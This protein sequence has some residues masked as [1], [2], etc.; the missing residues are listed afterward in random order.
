MGT[1]HITAADG[2][3]YEVEAA[4]DQAARELET[5]INTR[6]KAGD[7]QLMGAS[8]PGNTQ[9]LRPEASRKR[10]IT[11]PRN[12]IQDA[13]AKPDIKSVIMQGIT[14]GLSDEA[15]GLGGILANAI[16][17]PLSS[18]V[19]FDPSGAYRRSRDAE[20]ARIEATRKK[21][22]W[23]SFGGELGGSLLTGGGAAANTGKG[24]GALIRQGAKVGAASGALSGFGY[25]EGAENSLVGA[26][27]GA[28]LGGAIGAAVPVA[29]RLAGKTISGA[30]RFTSP[31]GGIGRNIVSRALEADNVSPR[32]AA[33]AIQEAE[34]RGVPLMLAD[35]GSNVRG[36]AGSLARKPGPSRTLAREAVLSRQEGQGERIRSAITRDLGPIMNPYEASDQLISRARAAAAPLYDDAYRAPVVGTP[37]LDAILNTPAGRQALSRA[38]TIAANERRDPAA[39]GFRLDADG[40]V[41]LEPTVNIGADEASNLTTFQNPAQQRGF[42]TQT[43]DYVKRGLDDIIE[44]NRD[45]VTRRLNLDEAG[46]AINDVRSSLVNEVDRLNPAYAQAR[47]A[48]QGP[49][50][51]KQAMELGRKALNASDQEIV[52]M[53]D[54]LTDSELDQFLLGYRSAMGDAVDRRVDGGDK[55]AAL[56]GTPR[57]RAALEQA[58]GDRA[59]LGRFGRTLQDER[60]AYETYR[61][62]N[63]GSP[64]AER[65]ADDAMTDDLALLQDATGKAIKGAATGGLAGL[66][67]SGLDAAGDVWKFG[68]GKA[69]ER[70][71]EDAAAL[72]FNTDRAA[73]EDAMRQAFKL[74]AA[75]R[76]RLQGIDRNA[77]YI[78]GLFGRG[79]G[80]VAAI[81]SRPPE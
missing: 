19:D 58:F 81:G 35:L 30:K 59:D 71:R 41:S 51:E 42:T 13:A 32:A 5:F 27:L 65:L 15:V 66:L 38:R 75:D 16:A 53:T 2:G 47:A 73:L 34:Q 76:L 68:A 33:L 31:Q 63:T 10:A 44:A 23:L 40:N 9:V 36:L 77:R 60:Q 22:P 21:S 57:K 46:R 55:A 49:A 11:P 70:A 12:A 39:L 37:E 64:T 48:Y 52:R 78:G 80:G 61:A 74:Q 17:A 67:A 28:G 43:L 8:A 4:N 3:V 79:A 62:I 20:R 54:G 69:G 14:A 26:G 7:P 56:L 24:L 6:I 72:L 50:R 25:G 45:P 18:K 29:S 1:Y